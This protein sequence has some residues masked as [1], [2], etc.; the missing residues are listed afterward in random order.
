MELYTPKTT[1]MASIYFCLNAQFN[2]RAHA[3]GALVVYRNAGMVR[4]RLLSLGGVSGTR[5]VQLG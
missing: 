2:H 3:S 1:K 4:A 5:V